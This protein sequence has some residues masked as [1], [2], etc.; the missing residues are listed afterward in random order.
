MKTIALKKD[1][2]PPEKLRILKA[3]F[4]ELQKPKTHTKNLIYRR[5]LIMMT[6]TM[7]IEELNSRGYIAEEATAI[8][9]GIRKEGITVKRNR[10]DRVA[11]NI[12]TDDFIEKAERENLSVSEVADEIENI[13]KHCNTNF[14]VSMFSDKDYVLSHI[15][16]GL[17]ATGTEDI[18]K[19]PSSFNGIEEYLYLE[20]SRGTE[21]FSVKVKKELL[22]NADVAFNIAWS[23]AEKNSHKE[24]TIQ[25]LFSMVANIIGEENPICNEFAPIY[26]V[27]NK[28]QFRGA[29]G[30][31]DRTALKELADN[32]GIHN[33]IVLPSSIHECILMPKDENTDMESL[34]K[35]VR[36][37]NSTVVSPEDKLIDAVFEL[38]A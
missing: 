17:Q 11:P 4:Q 21:H 24:T 34:Y 3:H 19:R 15:R 31:V 23:M 8:K 36:E 18:V 16:L 28:S 33:F 29:S 2:S 12:Y 38:T 25:P 35:M 20:G 1:R 32:I 5:N 37:V 14:D 26:V 7:I 22:N 9:N 30:I 27:S 13:V 6:R 10:T